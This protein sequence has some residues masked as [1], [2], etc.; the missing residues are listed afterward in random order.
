[1]AKYKLKFHNLTHS[2]FSTIGVLFQQRDKRQDKNDSEIMESYKWVSVYT[3]NF[4]N[5]YLKNDE[6]ALKFIENN[7]HDNGIKNSI[8]TKQAKKANSHKFTFED[9]N[10]LALKQD[11]NSLYNLYVSTKK[12]NPMMEIPEGSLNTLGLQLVFNPNTSEQGINV[13][14]LATKLYPK[15]ANLFDSLAEAY[16]FIENKEKAIENFKKSLE[17]NAQNQNAIN[18]LKQLKE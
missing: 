11:Y 15:S 9:F 17:L 5:T 1:M 12:K 18:R 3:L 8:L 2:Y 10:E 4:L 16:L 13:F 6:S 7:P 14:L